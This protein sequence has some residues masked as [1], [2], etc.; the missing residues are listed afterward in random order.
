[1]CGQAWQRA[2]GRNFMCRGEKGGRRSKYE[3]FSQPSASLV[4]LKA[5]RTLLSHLWSSSKRQKAAAEGLAGVIPIIL[6]HS[7][8][9]QPTDSLPHSSCRPHPVVHLHWVFRT[10]TMRRST[11]AFTDPPALHLESALFFSRFSAL[12]YFKPPFTPIRFVF[13]K[14]SLSTCHSPT[15]EFTLALSCSRN[16]I[17]NTQFLPAC[18]ETHLPLPYTSPPHSAPSSLPTTPTSSPACSILQDI[19]QWHSEVLSIVNKFSFPKTE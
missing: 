10:M 16:H 19:L 18:L 15:P 12:M 3:S 14:F 8:C 9:Q 2:L 5:F 1:M 4:T 6:R 7:E 11:N 17:P 13:P